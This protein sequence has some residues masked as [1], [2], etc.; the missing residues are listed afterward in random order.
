MIGRERERLA[1]DEQSAWRANA[2]NPLHILG[3]EG[4]LGIALTL[5]RKYSGD[6]ASAQRAQVPA[7]SCASC[8][9]G[10]PVPSLH[11]RPETH[12]TLGGTAPRRR[13]AR[14]SRYLHAP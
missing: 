5:H 12:R 1:A 13:A 2:E 3:S 9:T 14:V 4:S 8:P 11:L 7:E 10:R 6:L